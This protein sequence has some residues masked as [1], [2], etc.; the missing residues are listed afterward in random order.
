MIYHAYLNSKREGG[1]YVFIQP[2]TLTGT[3][4]DMNGGPYAQDTVLTIANQRRNV[5]NAVSGFGT[6]N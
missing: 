1:R 5:M 2:Y 6:V 3:T 4:I